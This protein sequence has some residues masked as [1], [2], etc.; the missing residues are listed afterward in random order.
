MYAAAMKPSTLARTTRRQPKQRR[1][2]ETF[3]AVLDA[4]MRILKREG[5]A[6]VTTNHIAEVAGVSI[7]SLYQYFPDKRAIFHALHSR[8][9][10][11]IDQLIERTLVAHACSALEELVKAL[12]E[13]MI[14]IH[15]GAPELYHALMTEVPHSSGGKQAFAVRLHGV[16]LLA[17]AARVNQ[18]KKHHDPLKT[19]FVVAHMIDSLSHAVVLRRPQGLSRSDLKKEAVR[20][21]LA[22]L[23]S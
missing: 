10:E 1:A 11:Q 9:I 6:A 2:L 3:D 15:E 14:E 4:V 16:F 22:Y 8:H 23:H 20:A 7:G 12:M 21:V 18:L 19:A 13:A 17:I 5:A